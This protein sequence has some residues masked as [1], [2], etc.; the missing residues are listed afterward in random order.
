MALEL[1]PVTLAAL[2]LLPL[3]IELSHMT[4]TDNVGVHR[5]VTLVRTG[6]VLP[7]TTPRP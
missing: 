5:T 1:L 6:T 3:L 2:L 7:C 4:C